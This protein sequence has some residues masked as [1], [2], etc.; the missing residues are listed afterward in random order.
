MRSK[1]V[2]PDFEE[3]EEEIRQYSGKRPVEM[4]IV[5]RP[6]VREP[7][8]THLRKLGLRTL[9]DYAGEPIEVLGTGSDKTTPD[10]D[11]RRIIDSLQSGLKGKQPQ[12]RLAKLDLDAPLRS[13]W[14]ERLSRIQEIRTADSITAIYK[15]GRSQFSVQVDGELDRK[16]GILWLSSDTDLKEAF[17]EVVAGLAFED[18]KRYYGSVLDRAYRMDMREHDP[19]QDANEESS[20]E[21]VGNVEAINQD[22]EGRGPSA[23]TAVHPVPK[24]DPAVN[25]PKPGPIPQGD[26]VMGRSATTRSNH[27]RPSSATE[28]AQ[29]TDLKEKQY[30]WHCQACLA[31]N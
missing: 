20:Q 16:S 13:N 3:L 1:I 29:I 19:L 24:S 5:E 11:F 4:A 27:R 6:R 7:A 14:R 25:I 15:L 30:A 28:N 22:R 23:T 12:K 2:I 21:D 31:G 8:T 17:F 26:D 9:S 18:P 10:F